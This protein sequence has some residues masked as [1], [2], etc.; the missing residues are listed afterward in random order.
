MRRIFGKVINEIAK[1]DK[2]IILIVGDIG[3]GIFDDFR[4]NHPNRFFN[5]GICEQSI[6][7][8]ASGIAL[9]GLK[10]WVYTI[11]PF[12]IERPFEQIKLDIDQQKSNVKLV[13]FADYPNLGPSHSELNAKKTMKVFKNIKTFF[14]KNSEQTKKLILKCHKIKGPTF[15]SLKTDKKSKK[16]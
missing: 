3:Y 12:L 16:F 10:P 1:K 15:V 5:L 7:G 11:T 2:K 14:P 9:Q 13:G 4:K 8:F 6:I